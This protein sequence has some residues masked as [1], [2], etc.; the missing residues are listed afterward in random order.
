MHDTFIKPLG[1]LLY[2]EN[3]KYQGYIY[4]VLAN[5][6]IHDDDTTATVRIGFPRCLV[7]VWKNE[8]KPVK[9]IVD[10]AMTNIEVY[11]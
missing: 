3:I 2:S 7:P 8:H 4:T 6:I 11:R 5:P 10:N 9:E 1:Q